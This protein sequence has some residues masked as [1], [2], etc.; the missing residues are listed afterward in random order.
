MPS[1]RNTIIRLSAS[2]DFTL[3][4]G[5]IYTG[6][7]HSHWYLHEII[8]CTHQTIWAGANQQVT[9]ARYAKV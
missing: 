1:I 8:P 3:I 6:I 7:K 4:G 9:V 2:S 5:S